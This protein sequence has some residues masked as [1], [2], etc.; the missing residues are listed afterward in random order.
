ML[1]I[2]LEFSITF[3]IQK[4]PLS[5]FLFKRENGPE[6]Y[7]SSFTLLKRA[8]LRWNKRLEDMEELKILQD[9]LLDAASM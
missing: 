3:T 7:I 2:S 9:R 5:V 8:D 4:P 1:N 6:S